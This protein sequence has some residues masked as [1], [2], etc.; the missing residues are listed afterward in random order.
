MMYPSKPRQYM[1][2]PIPIGRDIN[3]GTDNV[4][5]LTTRTGFLSILASQYRCTIYVVTSQLGTIS[6]SNYT[7]FRHR[8]CPWPLIGWCI[9]VNKCV[10]GFLKLGGVKI[11]EAIVFRSISNIQASLYKIMYW[12]GTA[13]SFIILNNQYLY[14]QWTRLLDHTTM[15]AEVVIAVCHRTFVRSSIIFIRQ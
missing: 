8:Q 9:R 13:V 14:I 12:L 15:H 10:T 2:C 6:A 3:N 7:T 11:L 4:V 5:G 1:M